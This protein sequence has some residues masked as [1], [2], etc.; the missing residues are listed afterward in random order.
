[1]NN[2][3]VNLL[4]PK[5][6]AVLY[7]LAFLASLGYGAWLASDGDWKKA[8]ASFIG[9]LLAATAASNASPTPTKAKHANQAGTIDVALLLIVLTFVG[10][11]LLL[12]GVHA[13][14][15]AGAPIP[16]MRDTNWPCAAC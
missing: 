10:V 4:T 16:S 3:L 2:P 12:L 11:V 7:A 1:M 8:I 6:R 5:V 15:V 9:A 14:D 13:H